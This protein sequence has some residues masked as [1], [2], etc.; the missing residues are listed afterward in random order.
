MTK[1][2]TPTAPAKDWKK[3]RRFR[4]AFARMLQKVGKRS[5]RHAD[6]DGRLESVAILAQEKLGD[7]ILLT[8]LI[9]N[10]RRAFPELS[11]HVIVF[12]KAVFDFFSSDRNVTAV[13]NAKRAT[14]G[15]IR[16]VL[17][18]RFDLLYNT[19]DHP[20]THFLI[21]SILIP[22][23]IKAGIANPFHEGLYDQLLDITYHT[24]I[25]TKNCALLGLLGI[26]APPETCRPY[27]PEMRVQPELQSFADSMPDRKFI[28]INISAGGPLRY[29]TEEKWSALI[30]R[31]PDRQFIIFSAPQ[32][33]ETKLRLETRTNVRPSVSTRNI[34]EVGLLVRKLRLL[35]T[36]DTSL[37][38]VASCFA[39]PLIGLY[40]EALQDLTRFAPYITDH[41]LIAS[42]TRKV[43]DIY[44]DD[45]ARAVEARLDVR[46]EI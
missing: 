4:Q 13:H 22:A 3:K 2:V 14:P 15:Y 39:V 37:I 16:N 44:V 6:F 36:P 26:D 23:R 20:S 5:A 34:Y 9:G 25:V 17:L 21:Q 27:I 28:G 45:V 11:I 8:P 32:D 29:W 19:K 31:F 41:T 18:H 12:S 10:L 30:D 38:H 24:H 42:P 33:R 35:V 40:R 7:A 1:P 46:Q 43:C